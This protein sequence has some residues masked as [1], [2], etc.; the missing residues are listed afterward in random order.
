MASEETAPNKRTW[1]GA[2]SRR[3]T[4]T[5]N[6]AFATLHVH[7]PNVP[8]DMNL[9]KM[10]TLRLATCYIRFLMKSLE[11]SDQE[12]SPHNFDLVFPG[13]GNSG[14]I[15]SVI[16]ASRRLIMNIC[17]TLRLPHHLIPLQCLVFFFRQPADS[18]PKP[19]KQR[20]VPDRPS[21]SGKAN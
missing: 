6:N 12:R 3:S 9:L 20:K 16:R 4:I 11:K 17:E 8:P 13:E 19:R 2:V 14:N 5:M 7:I 18:E 1:C 10:R 15:V 21:I